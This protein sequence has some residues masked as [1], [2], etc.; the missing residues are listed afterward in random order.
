GLQAH[1][2]STLARGGRL[3]VA[4]LQAT[5]D[6][7]VAQVNAHAGR[8]MRLRDTQLIAGRM[9]AWRLVLEQGASQPATV[10]DPGHWRYHGAALASL[11]SLVGYRDTEGARSLGE[12]G[13]LLYGP[14][15]EAPAGRYRL[16]VFGTAQQARTAWVDVAARVGS[17]RYAQFALRPRGDV[18]VDEVVHLPRS[19]RDLEVRVYV[20]AGDVLRVTGYEWRRCPS[21]LAGARFDPCH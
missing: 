16:Q 10:T 12:E 3:E 20:G 15:R 8:P 7:C 18:L 4:C 13:F 2:A 9:A 21:S 17:V 5:V 1:V 14:Y 11:N 19:E 6:G